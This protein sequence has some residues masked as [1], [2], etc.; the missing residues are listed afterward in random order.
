MWVCFY[1]F[2]TFAIFGEK[3][4]MSDVRSMA[5]CLVGIIIGWQLEL[6]E[7]ELK[8]VLI[9]YAGLTLFVGVM[10]II[11]N[12]GGLE[13]LDQYHVDNKN[14]LGVMLTTSATIFMCFGF[15]WQRNKA[16]SFLYWLLALIAF[17]VLL[18]IRARTATL[19]TV[20]MLP[21]LYYQRFKGKNFFLYLVLG[22]LVLS[23]IYS[24]LPTTAKEYVYYSFFQNYEGG[25]VT[26]GRMATYR[27]ALHL[28]SDHVLLGNLNQNVTIDWIHNYPLNRTFEFGLIFVFPILLLYFYLLIISIRNTVH[29]DK[30]NTI[31][32]GSLLVIPFIISMAEPT[33]PFGPGTATVFNFIIFGASIAETKVLL[34]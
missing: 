29:S 7:K 4:M 18:T 16:V 22:F 21:L 15:N 26:S 3:S 20:L 28:L 5:I 12:I 24:V 10:Q 31:N 2:I 30:Y 11:Q 34:V 25:D 6:K 14:S 1:Y 33:F 19:A 8:V 17:I 32:V 27:D 13:I 9:I 23:L